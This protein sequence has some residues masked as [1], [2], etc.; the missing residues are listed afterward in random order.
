MPNLVILI[1]DKQ[2]IEIVFTT[3]IWSFC[4]FVPVLLD[5]PSSDDTCENKFAYTHWTSNSY[6]L[7]I[8]L[9]RNTRYIRLSKLFFVLKDLQF[10]IPCSFLEFQR[11]WFGTQADFQPISRDFL[12]L[13]HSS[14]LPLYQLLFVFSFKNKNKNPKTILSNLQ[15]TKSITLYKSLMI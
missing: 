11:G 7:H 9:S 2:I 3:A 1:G 8:S 12:G 15:T 5:I 6:L 10:F 14:P 13:S 4:H